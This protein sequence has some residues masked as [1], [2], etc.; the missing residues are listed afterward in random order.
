MTLNV[1]N[2]FNSAQWQHITRSL[3]QLN[4]PTYFQVII[5][6]YFGYRKLLYDADEY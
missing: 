5:T 4:V 3:S 6:D 2:G 1:G